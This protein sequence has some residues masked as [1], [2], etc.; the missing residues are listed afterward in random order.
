[1]DEEPDKEGRNGQAGGK[2]R[3]E[4]SMSSIEFDGSNVIIGGTVLLTS[5]N[6][7]GFMGMV[8]LSSSLLNY[9]ESIW[10]LVCGKQM[11]FLEV[12]VTKLTSSGEEGE[13]TLIIME[14]G[15]RSSS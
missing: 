12:G 1:M 6:F 9:G 5:G 15:V 4:L 11:R 10:L 7:G 2:E 3:V 8:L 13:L 14:S